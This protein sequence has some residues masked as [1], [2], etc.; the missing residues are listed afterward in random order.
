M[1]P[2]RKRRNVNR[3]ITPD[4]RST[5]MVEDVKRTIAFETAVVEN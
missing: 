5:E 1:Y 4:V 2:D 3:H